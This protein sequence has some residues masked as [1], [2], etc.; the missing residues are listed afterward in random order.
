M[1]RL[2]T[3]VLG[4][5][6]VPRLRLP[7][8]SG[9]PEG[10]AAVL[11]VGP[12]AQD[13]APTRRG[14]RRRHSQNQ[15][16]TDGE[17]DAAVSALRTPTPRTGPTGT[18]RC[19]RR[20]TTSTRGAAAGCWLR[21]G[22]AIAGCGAAPADLMTPAAQRGATPAPSGPGQRLAADARQQHAG[23]AAHRAARH[24]RPGRGPP[25]GRRAP[26][27]Q[28]AAGPR[29][30]GRGIRGND[31]PA[32]L[33]RGVPVPRR[34]LGGAGGADPARGR[35]GAVRPAPAHRLRRRH[36]L[37]RPGPGQ[38]PGGGRGLRPPSLA[39]PRGCSG[40]DRVHERGPAG[41]PGYRA[42]AA[43]HLPGLR[44]REEERSF[45]STGAWRA[46]SL[47]ITAPGQATQAWAFGGAQPPL[48]P[49]VRRPVRAGGQHRGAGA[50][51][52][53]PCSSAASSAS[54]RPVPGSSARVPPSYC[55]RRARLAGAP[56]RRSREPGPSRGFTT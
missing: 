27:W 16:P 22:S 18:D 52:T 20:W 55:R 38:D 43:V 26:V 44:R 32:A 56:A 23:G 51:R 19:G 9:P 39:V 47:K 41:G 21:P 34:R 28:P 40:A 13:H 7:A 33:H 1:T 3:P 4:L 35:A 29:V 30:R 48:A 37:V 5:V 2:G 6:A 17:D 12:A 46:S 14:T 42:A 8:P 54:P 11:R 50:S 36:S 31:L 24:R 45:A 10:R 49:G 53:R 25:C 15:W